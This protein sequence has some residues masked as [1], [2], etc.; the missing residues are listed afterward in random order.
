MR[1]YVACIWSVDCWKIC[2]R[3]MKTVD[4]FRPKALQTALA[5]SLPKPVLQTAAQLPS[6]QISIRPL[7]RLRPPTRRTESSVQR[8]IDYY[9]WC[10]CEGGGATCNIIEPC[11]CY[12]RLVMLYVRWQVTPACC[13]RGQFPTPI[14]ELL[15]WNS[16]VSPPEHCVLRTKV[17]ASP[18]LNCLATAP[19]KN[20]KE[21]ENGCISFYACIS[22]SYSVTTIY[23][24]ST[25]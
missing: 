22:H 1:L 4:V 14:P 16:S 18:R 11:T 13:M 5:S 10:V 3:V 25:L 7:N 2:P 21:R 19:A 12:L 8:P 9:V 6:L 15:H 17:G 24:A 20:I 23:L